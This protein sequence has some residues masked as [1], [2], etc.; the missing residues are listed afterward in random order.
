MESSSSIRKLVAILMADVVGYS[1][2]MG[3]DEEDTIKRIKACR[4]IFSEQVSKHGGRIV[5]APGDSILAEFA[6]VKAAVASAVEIQTSLVSY[7][8]TA[9]PGNEMQ[10][11]IG[12]NLGDVVV[13]DDAI[14]GNGINVAARLESLADH[15]GITISG[16]V[17]DSVRDQLD[18]TFEFTG[19][20]SVKNIANPVR[21]Y[22]VNLDGTAYPGAEQQPRIVPAPKKFF[23]TWLVFF[24]NHN[25]LYTRCRFVLARIEYA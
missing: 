8:R 7:N 10:F 17:Y 22:R 4:D 13:E 15:G 18:L 20:Q 24:L 23:S 3:Q 6:S 19:E 11:R 16:S 5:N 21:T 14:Y 2:L 25:R 12:I 9:T 1:R